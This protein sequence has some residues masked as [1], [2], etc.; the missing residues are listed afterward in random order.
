MVCRP[1]NRF[2]KISFLSITTFPIFGTETKI[3]SYQNSAFIIINYPP[4][5]C[6]KIVPKNLYDIKV[7]S[8]L[9]L[10]L[11]GYTHVNFRF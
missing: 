7:E 5:R 11:S 4:S 8:D 6:T 9:T 10:K 3:K 2:A 1:K